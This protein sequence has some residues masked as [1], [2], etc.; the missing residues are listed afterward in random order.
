MMELKTHVTDIVLADING[1]SML[2]TDLQ[3][4]SALYITGQLQAGL[5][6]LLD[7]ATEP[8]DKILLGFIPTG[9]GFY[10]LLQPSLAGYG[11]FLAI[12]IRS[13]LLMKRSKQTLPFSGVRLAVHNGEIAPFTDLVGKPNFVGEG[14]NSC[15]RLLAARPENARDP[16]LPTDENSIVVSEAAHQCFRKLC[17]EDAEL[18]TFLASIQYQEGEWFEL[19]DKHGHVRRAR[20]VDASRSAAIGLP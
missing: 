1:Y 14:L 20:F 2:P 11:I 8:A 12:S 4:A 17:G 18:R 5:N 16:T 10:V 7:L 6:F 9:D 19:T 15:A 3:L 13:I